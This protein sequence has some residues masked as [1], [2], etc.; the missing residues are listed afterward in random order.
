MYFYGVHMGTAQD[1]CSGCLYFNIYEAITKV[2]KS[3]EGTEVINTY[4]WSRS[5]HVSFVL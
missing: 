2:A 1:N 5:S 4:F 3:F